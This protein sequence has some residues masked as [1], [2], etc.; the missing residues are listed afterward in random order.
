[1]NENEIG[2]IIVDTA[3]QLHR[4]LGPGLLETVYEVVL[5]NRL[6]RAGLRV[7]RQVSVPIQFDGESFDEGFRADL[8]VENRVIIEL[9]SVEKLNSA[10]KKQLLTYLRLTGLKL[11]YLLNFGNELMKNGISRIINGQLDN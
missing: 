11:G 10:H 8:I 4:G 5:A 9:K 1:M 2:T 7:E 6:R 3:M